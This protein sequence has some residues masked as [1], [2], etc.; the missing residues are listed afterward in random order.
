MSLPSPDLRSW[1]LSIALG[2]LFPIAA[3]PTTAQ[4]EWTDPAPVNTNA[5]ND[6]DSDLDPQVAHDGA[7][8]WVAVWTTEDTLGGTIGTD[9][10]IL[11][12]HSGDNGVTWSDV[13][14]LNTNAA[15]D[16]GTDGRPHIASD[17][18]GNWVA[19][20]HSTENLGAAIG[21][22]LD[23]LVSRSE[24]N[25]ATWTAPAAL[26]T[27]ANADTSH[28]FDPFIASDGKGI[29]LTVW[30]NT[31][32]PGNTGEDADIL[33]SRSMDNGATWSAPATLNTNAT[34]DGGADFIPRI[35]TDG[36]GN[37]VAV[38]YSNETLGDTIGLDND[39]FAASSADDGAS[40]SAPTVVND[41]AETDGF[42]DTN[43]EIATDR[44]GNWVVVWHSAS[45]AARGQGSDFDVA[46]ASSADNGANWTNAIALN[47]NASTDTGNDFLPSID[48]DGAGTWVT[49]WQSNENLDDVLGTDDDV[50]FAQSVNNGASWTAPAALN[51]GAATDQ[52]NDWTPR[53]GSNR[54][55]Q[56]LAIWYSWEDLGEPIGNDFDILAAISPLPCMLSQAFFNALP[57]WGSTNTVLDLITIVNQECGEAREDG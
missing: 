22:D 46:V 17:G 40:W 49:V 45:V 52:G 48:T 19:V 53:I 7:G 54:A 21:T 38:W 55:G 8:N 6:E 24:D 43:P 50:F 9:N 3:V 25:G 36:S 11:V 10:D 20:W 57:N 2:L 16:S 56:W 32:D 35:A 47:T 33:F 26:N 37:W 28:D 12:A 29:W 15:N 5:A 1:C 44:A 18:A 42:E 34:T 39:I 27:T 30:Y 4:S 31:L 41:N 23:I 14:P 51:T 13:M